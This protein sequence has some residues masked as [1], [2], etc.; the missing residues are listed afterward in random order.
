MD[1]GCGVGGPACYIGLVT[2]AEIVGINTNKFQIERAKANTAMYNLSDRISYVESDFNDVPFE[3]NYF[4]AVYSVEAICYS[5]DKVKT[6]TEWLRV[7]K[8]GGYLS[9][10]TWQTTP[11]FDPNNKVHQ[12][13]KRKIEQGVGLPYLADCDEIWKAAEAAGFELLSHKDPGLDPSLGDG[14]YPWYWSL[15]HF[16]SFSWEGFMQ[17]KLS[18]ML[19]KYLVVVMENYLKLAPKGTTKVHELLS[20]SA[21]G[22]VDGGVN[23]VFIPYYHICCRK[24]ELK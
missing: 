18:R 5:S 19:T 4:D 16:F 22:L 23:G 2:E 20:V 10:T 15:G 1:A 8:P 21:E 3:D 6:L 14:V 12:E 11:K 17:S 9:L 7:L 24:P 13:I